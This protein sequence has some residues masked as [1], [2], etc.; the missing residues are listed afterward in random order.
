MM[1]KLCDA[2]VIVPAPVKKLVVIRADEI[3]K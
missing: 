3:A 2:D 1:K